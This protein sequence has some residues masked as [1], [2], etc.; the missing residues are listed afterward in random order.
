MNNLKLLIKFP[1]RSRPEKFFSVLE[2]YR[3]FQATD[4]VQYVVSCDI[5]DITMNNKNVIDKLT[6]Y[7]DLDFYFSIF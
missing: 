4:N 7:N 6:T 2:K 1:T 5:D 3:T